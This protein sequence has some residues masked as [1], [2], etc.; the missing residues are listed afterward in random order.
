MRAA[1]GE[2]AAA[3]GS[4]TKELEAAATPMDAAELIFNHPPWVLLTAWPQQQGS[5]N[6]PGRRRKSHEAAATGN[7]LG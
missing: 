1:V 3:P 7:S 2:S 6:L 5:G 4:F